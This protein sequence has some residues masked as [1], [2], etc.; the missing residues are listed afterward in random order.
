MGWL[1]NVAHSVR[2][3]VQETTLPASMRA[4]DANHNS[5]LVNAR[6]KTEAAAVI[7]GNYYLPGS[8]LLTSRLSSRYAQKDL[9]GDVG[10]IAQLASGAAGLGIGSSYTGIGPSSWGQQMQIG[11]DKGT[12]WLSHFAGGFA[13]K[14][15]P[16]F[17]GKLGGKPDAPA[18]DAQA[19]ALD[20]MNYAD[21][22]RAH[23]YD[24]SGST[25][26]FD[27]STPAPATAT[28]PASKIKTQ[29]IVIAA[30]LAGLGLEL[31]KLISKR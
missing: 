3:T 28:A 16:M 12:G 17:A 27:Y 21:F 24:M 22:S 19:P 26:G 2:N 29:H 14:V 18:P 7:V 1:S 30:G 4:K 25:K 15:A 5:I 10:K 11:F 31:I 20:A 8:S 23:G 9:G 13:G 6:D